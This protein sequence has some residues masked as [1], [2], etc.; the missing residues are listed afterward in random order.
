MGGMEE[1]KEIIIIKIIR[2][3]HEGNYQA[4]LI[5]QTDK[6]LLNPWIFGGIVVTLQAK[7][8]IKQGKI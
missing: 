4:N 3:A 1:G 2:L 5:K 6:Y 7:N 8:H